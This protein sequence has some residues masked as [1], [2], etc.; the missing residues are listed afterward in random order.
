V[1]QFTALRPS[2]HDTRLAMAAELAKRSLCSRDRVGAV[3]VD[4]HNKVIG[5]GYNGPPRGFWHGGESCDRWCQRT[6]NAKI[7]TKLDGDESRGLHPTYDDCPS[8]HAEANALLMADRSLCAGGTIFVTSYVCMGCAK[9]IAN[10]GLIRVVVRSADK[11]HRPVEATLKFLI[12]C[13]IDVILYEE[14]EEEE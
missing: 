14:F 7:A 2:W 10:S 5:E 9:L 8:L 1:T 11:S 12:V 13:K 6:M 4:R 3:I